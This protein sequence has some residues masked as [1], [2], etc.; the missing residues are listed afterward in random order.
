[1]VLDAPWIL[2][3]RT[4]G[5]LAVKLIVQIPCLNEEETLPLTVKDIPRQIDGID[6]VEILVINDGST[7]R[8]VEVAREIG[9]NHIIS[10]TKNKGLAKGFM[11]GLDACLRFGADIIVNTDADNQY[12]GA[13]IP[14]LIQPIIEGKADMVIG[15]RQIDTIEHFSYTKKKLQR[16]GSYVVRRASGTNIP[17]TT[18]GF[19]AYNREAALRLNVISDFTYTLETIIQAG[20]K[21]IALT[22]VPIGTNE[23]LRES[24]LFSSVW[25]YV[26]LST[27]TIIRIY[28]MF[29]PLKTFSYIG[30]GIFFLGILLGLRYLYFYFSGS[31]AGH[32]QS[33]IL[34]AVFLLLGFQ[35]L[36]VGLIADLIASN[37][38]LIE[39]L[40]YRIRK[41]EL[42]NKGKDN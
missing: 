2:S 16:L 12:C 3:H 30:A 29:E 8:T 38:R 23:K 28:A 42:S 32:I 17:D 25:K 39:D 24:R 14:K 33:V 34:A 15:D 41:L 26:K 27:S 5:K 40:L 4:K 22:S 31:G 1:L 10:F 6:E 11:A 18:S 21:Q 19:R 20:K 36:V 13:D 37:R 7:D 9:V 35:I